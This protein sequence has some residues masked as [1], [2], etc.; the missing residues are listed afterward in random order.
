MNI[1]KLLL[2]NFQQWKKGEIEFKPGL[3]I[4][5]GDTECGKSTLFRAISSILTGKMPEN[6]IRKNEKEVEVKIE[7]DNNKYFKRFR[8]KKDNIADAN[9][10]I[11]ERVGKD[12]PFDYFKTL[13]NTKI[14]FGNKELNL[15]LYS[16]FEPHFF[17]TLSDYDKSKLI[18]TICGID[19]IDKLV[20]GINKDIRNNNTNIKFL[21]S[22]IEEKKKEN[23]NKE[24]DFIL[25]DSKYKLL[26]NKINIIQ[27]KFKILQNLSNL[28]SNKILLE[29]NINIYQQKKNKNKVILDNFKGLNIELLEKLIKLYNNLYSIY[30][31]I[32]SSRNKFKQVS[33]I[34]SNFSKNLPLLEKLDNINKKLKTYEDERAINNTVFTS[35]SLKLEELK[36]QQSELL[37]DFDNCPLCGSILHD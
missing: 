8:S 30:S 22:Q 33:S 17:I 35:N 9:G 1:K 11:F 7:F 29:N 5:V 20:D 12:I 21:N 27:D 25:I 31:D 6:Y 16:Q 18:G 13:G 2:N 4:I 24:K 10:T 19:I 14:D 36:K 28:S 23:E 26:E 3:N 15:C 32:I 37:K 34:S